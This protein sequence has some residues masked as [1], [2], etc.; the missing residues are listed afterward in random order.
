MYVVI[1]APFLSRK[2]QGEPSKGKPRGLAI[3]LG[4]LS[5]GYKKNKPQFAELRERQTRKRGGFEED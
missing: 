2:H 4:W 3:T 5:T 1:G